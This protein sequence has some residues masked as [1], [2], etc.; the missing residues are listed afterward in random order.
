ME[1]HTKQT[2]TPNPPIRLNSTPPGPWAAT[3]KDKADLFAN[4]LLD[5]FTPHDQELDQAVESE[6]AK[7]VHSTARLPAF[8]LQNLQQEI[9]KLKKRKAPGLDNIT[10]Q[11]LKEI[12]KEG[13]I[14]LLH[15]YNAV[16]RCNYW[17]ADFKSAQ[18]IMA[19]KP[20]KDPTD[21][22]SYRPISLL[23]TISKILEKLI[24]RQISI[25]TEL[26]TWVPHHQFGFRKTHSTIQQCHRITH[27]VNTALEYKQYCTAA[28]LDISQAF[29]KVWHPGLLCKIKRLLPLG[30][31]P[32]LKSYLQDRTYVTKVNTA[33]SNM[34]HIQSGVPQGSILGPLLY[35]LYTSDLP[36]S[37][38]TVISTFTDDTAIVAVDQNPNTA[39]QNFK[40]ISPAWGIGYAN[41]W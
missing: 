19:L 17:P 26:N 8:T 35:T 21:V 10:S 4:Y 12:P 22:T 9:I 37:K 5:V 30:Y 38:H 39:S 29:D 6:L 13:L 11:M 2:Q 27:T 20:G 24:S 25:D 14:K 32:L 40:T 34:H 18:I 1:T 36:T 3:D 7:P 33:T 23:S 16:V 15:I 31:F 41:G 28:F